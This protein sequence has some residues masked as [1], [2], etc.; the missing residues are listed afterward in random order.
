MKYLL[1]LICLLASFTSCHEDNDKQTGKSRT[2]LVYIS[3]ENQLSEYSDRNISQMVKGSKKLDNKNHL[4]VYVDKATP[5]EMPYIAEIANGEI[6]VVRTFD[7]DILSSDP[8]EMRDIIKWTADNYPADDYGLVLWGHASG[9]IMEDSVA[10]SLTYGPRKAFGVDNGRN[11]KL[12]DVGKWLNI[13]SMAQCIEETGIKF[14]FIFADVCCFQCVENVYELRNATEWLIGSPAEI[15]GYGAPYDA[16]MPYM[17]STSPNFYKGMIDEYEKFYASISV[18]GTVYSVPLSA[19][20]TSEATSLVQAANQ[21]WGKMPIKNIS[22]DGCIYYF[23]RYYIAGKGYDSNNIFY[24]AYDIVR[25]NTDAATAEAW[26]N[27]LDRM[28]AYSS[29]N[30]NR[31]WLSSYVN[32]FKNQH[33]IFSDFTITHEKMKCISM[34]VPLRVYDNGNAQYNEMIK[35]TAWYYASGLC[36]YMN[37]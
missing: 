5:N 26:N 6:K 18:N 11:D 8:R 33:V 4:I 36:N 30:T 31:I 22:A 24:D 9:W 35:S 2:V 37:Q 16:I 19:A 34:F 10:T 13:S 1:T 25:A 28:I 29:F 14:K 32:Y 12:S 23:G 7:E 17:F 21:I 15:P 3:A 20:N 27:A